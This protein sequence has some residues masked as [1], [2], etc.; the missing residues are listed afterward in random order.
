[1]SKKTNKSVKK[2]MKKLQKFWA[3]AYEEDETFEAWEAKIGETKDGN[4]FLHPADSEKLDAKW[5]K[6]YRTSVDKSINK[7][8]ASDAEVEGRGWRY[9][10]PHAYFG[11]ATSSTKIVVLL[12]NPRLDIK[13][14]DSQESVFAQF[15]EGKPFYP[16]EKPW[17]ED[18]DKSWEW[19]RRWLWGDRDEYLCYFL[20]KE[21][22]LKH[23]DVFQLEL[24]PYPTNNENEFVLV[25]SKNLLP[26]QK[27]AVDVLAALLEDQSETECERIYILPSEKLFNVWKEMLKS[28]HVNKRLIKQFEKNVVIKRSAQNRSLTFS[29][30]VF[31]SK[32]KKAFD[33]TEKSLKGFLN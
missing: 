19:H 30:L 21:K 8:I 16:W 25:D 14:T 3:K 22:R 4:F 20:G 18:E 9:A 31:L 1:M 17:E 33:K 32:L 24:F 10:P 11:E 2:A 15:K 12:I 29:N 26:S 13:T 27:K 5:V 23:D 7:A 6:S 28:R